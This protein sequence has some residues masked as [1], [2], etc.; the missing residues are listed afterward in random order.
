MA[1]KN[2]QQC[3]EELASRIFVQNVEAALAVTPVPVRGLDARETKRCINGMCK[4]IMEE[5][6]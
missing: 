6:L 4:L 1:I 5:S 3:V 2:F